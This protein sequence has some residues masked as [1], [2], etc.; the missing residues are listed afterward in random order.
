V[1][2][3]TTASSG[4]GTITDDDDKLTSLQGLGGYH[5]S[6]KFDDGTTAYFAVSVY[7]DG[8]NGIP[9]F[10]DPWKSVVATL[11]HELSEAR[12]DP[13][14]EEVNRTGNSNLL[15]WYGDARGAGEIGDIPMN[16][17]G[18]DLSKVF[19]EVPVKGGTAPV[20]LMW[21]NAVHGPAEP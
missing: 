11:Y 2:L 20:Q 14:V 9:A 8:D 12:T 1:V 19:V 13:D 5:G 18:G 6:H 16:E 21:S 3:D 17:A 10:A 7:S 15:G 4:V